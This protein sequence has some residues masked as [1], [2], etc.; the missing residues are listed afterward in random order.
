MKVVGVCDGKTL[1]LP[2]ELREGAK[3][4]VTVLSEMYHTLTEEADKYF[5]NQW[6]LS[7]QG[8]KKMREYLGILPSVS[9]IMPPKTSFT[10]VP[11]H[12]VFSNRFNWVHA[13]YELIVTLG[14]SRICIKNGNFYIDYMKTYNNIQNIQHN[15]YKDYP[16]V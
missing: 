14:G 6:T 2:I 15:Y 1:V 10:N 4:C 12:L 9:D 3:D 5:I 16:L 7:R 13:E 11:L 8:R